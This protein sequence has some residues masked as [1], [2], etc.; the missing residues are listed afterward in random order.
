MAVDKNTLEKFDEI[1]VVNAGANARGICGFAAVYCLI[2]GR[3]GS[4]FENLLASDHR[5]YEKNQDYITIL[6]T[7]V[8]KLKFP[9]SFATFIC[10]TILDWVEQQ[11][12]ML[13]EMREFA[14]NWART[15]GG[16]S[17]DT[18]PLGAKELFR[19]LSEIG[20]PLTPN[21]IIDLAEK[22]KIK[23]NEVPWLFVPTTDEFL[24]HAYTN[25]LPITDISIIGL[26]DKQKSSSQDLY[27]GLKHW[28]LVHKG[29]AYTYGKRIH[30]PVKNT[31]LAELPYLTHYL[32]IPN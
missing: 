29:T 27:F 2:Y 4:E 6:T 26:S 5:K 25:D 18:N 32:Q 12:T 1:T 30:Y 22:Y 13:S 20:I 10:T 21:N 8:N 28:V 15:Y 14:I 3:L 7:L 23:I 17:Y 31:A 9:R 16:F 19:L 11:G 24:L